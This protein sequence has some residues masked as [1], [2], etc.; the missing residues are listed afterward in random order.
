MWH[1]VII[2]ECQEIY[3]GLMVMHLFGNR[4]DV[5]SNFARENIII[6]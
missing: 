4:V 1:D 6:F 3:D 2:I 5:S